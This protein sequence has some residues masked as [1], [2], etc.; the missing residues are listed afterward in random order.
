MNDEI[1]KLKIEISNLEK[2]VKKGPTP[3][4]QIPPQT[5]PRTQQKGNKS[6]LLT[7]QKGNKSSPSKI[8]P[9]EENFD[10]KAAKVRVEEL[11]YK[12][13]N[14]KVELEQVLIQKDNN[15]KNAENYKTKAEKEK[16]KG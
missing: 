12:L 3:I 11:K 5:P 1:G 14:K 4:R 6:L 9:D 7:P 10:V 15:I 13:E 2:E 8:E 16:Y